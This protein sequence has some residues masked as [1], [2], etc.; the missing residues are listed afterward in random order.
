MK[1]DRYDKRRR[2]GLLFVVRRRCNGIKVVLDRGQQDR[3]HHGLRLCGCYDRVHD[4]AGPVLFVPDD[5]LLT[6]EASC[7]GIHSPQISTAVL[8]PISL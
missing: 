4:Y 8:S 5:T 2:R 3:Q 6:A 7:L 1:V